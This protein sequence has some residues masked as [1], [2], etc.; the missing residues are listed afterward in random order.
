MIF[1]NLVEGVGWEC[2]LK[3]KIGAAIAVLTLGAALDSP[4]N[5]HVGVPIG[6]NGTFE[7][8]IA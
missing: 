7:P 3:I 6:D 8:Q 5:R 1:V 4:G 2:F